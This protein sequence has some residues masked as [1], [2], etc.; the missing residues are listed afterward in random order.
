MSGSGILT[1]LPSSTPPGAT[2]TL[3]Y[4]MLDVARLLGGL[5][6]SIATGGTTTTLIDTSRNEEAEYWKDGT[7]WIMSGTQ[8]GVCA[9]IKSHSGNTITLNTTLSSAI[10]AGTEYY[11]YPPE[12]KLDAIRHAIQ[13]SLR[14]LGDVTSNNTSLLTNTVSEEYILPTGVYNLLR[15]E[16]A[17]NQEEPYNYTRNYYWNE[18]NGKLYFH[19]NKKPATDGNKIRIWYKAPHIEV[20]EYSDIISDA[21]DRTWLAWAAVANVLRNTISITGKDKAINIDL[22]NQAI[23]R[24]QELRNRN[25]K[26]KMGLISP[27]PI[28]NP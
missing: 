9:G 17:T 22:L 24:E 1:P 19:P 6:S 23:M 7:V 3:S 15:V 16:T 28:L 10:V 2:N 12:F 26:K 18:S 14:E 21:I 5:R 11:V 25:N 8:I 13:S 20:F 27:D 4:A